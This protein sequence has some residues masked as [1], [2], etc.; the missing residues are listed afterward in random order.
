MR[1]SRNG[2]GMAD[3]SE[4]R[5]EFWER[6]E[7]DELNADE[8]EALCDGCGRCCLHRF[9][10]DDDAIVE[11]PVACRL[12]DVSTCRCRDYPNRKAKV[13]S[14]LVLTPATV[15]AYPWLPDTCAYVR[16]HRGESLP[17]WHHLRSGSRDTVH[18]VGVGVRGQVVSERDA[19]P[20]D[21][22][23]DLLD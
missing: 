18:E 5:D 2:D 9:E 7:L 8:W 6:F 15:G 22:L 3:S 17:E 4:L 23:A 11:V 21:A 16:L 12:L 14:C 10:L 19:D 1:I 20:L 13:P